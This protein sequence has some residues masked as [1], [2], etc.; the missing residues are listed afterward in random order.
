MKTFRMKTWIYQISR[1][2][3]GA[4]NG[5]IYD[6]AGGDSG[7]SDGR[8]NNKTGKMLDDLQLAV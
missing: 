5:T 8:S 6:G 7:D 2:T 4:F 1:G 3:T